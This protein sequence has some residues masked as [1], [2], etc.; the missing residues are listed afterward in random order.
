[1]VK[2]VQ[3]PSTVPTISEFLSVSD[4]KQTRKKKRV[5]K[6][7]EEMLAKMSPWKAFAERCRY[8]CSITSIHGWNHI[9]QLEFS[10]WER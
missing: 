1:M 8:Y 5:I 4:E 10:K 9:V 6:T 3:T 2:V 7:Q